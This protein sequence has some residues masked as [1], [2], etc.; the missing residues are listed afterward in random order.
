MNP[1]RRPLDEVY[2]T[3]PTSQATSEELAAALELL[4]D[5][6]SQDPLWQAAAATEDAA[7]RRE[8]VKG[9]MRPRVRM[10]TP[11]GFL[12]RDRATKA[13]VGHGAITATKK[14]DGAGD[15]ET[16]M[17]KM[18]AEAHAPTAARFKTLM[19]QF[20]A[21]GPIIDEAFARA[22]VTAFADGG[23]WLLQA[24]TVSPTL[25]GVG[26]GKWIVRK[27]L[28]GKSGVFLYTQDEINV[29]WYEKLGFELVDARRAELPP[30]DNGLAKSYGNWTMIYYPRQ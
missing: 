24:I 23:P 12:V 4:C 30:S 1:P 18:M 10:L 20:S 6:F 7:E 21:L 15:T 16:V 3:I 28:E 2:E 17:R 19:G 22:G 9:F 25:R 27:L 26:L 13:I 8:I 29:G 5:G 14:Q 11:H